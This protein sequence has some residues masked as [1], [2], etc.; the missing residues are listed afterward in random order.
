MN[1]HY[2]YIARV[3]RGVSNKFPDDA[4]GSQQSPTLAATYLRP[5]PDAD[6]MAC[7]ST[8]A[9]APGHAIHPIRGI[10]TSRVQETTSSLPRPGFAALEMV[11]HARCSLD[12][13]EP[14]QG[15]PSD[16]RAAVNVVAGESLTRSIL[17]ER[18]PE[19]LPARCHRRPTQPWQGLFGT[20]ASHARRWQR[21]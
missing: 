21:R 16:M 10:R 5:P 18:D 17:H 7:S 3:S 8:P 14:V 15:S 2:S 1:Y 11:W 12:H 19:S 9:V 6:L 13:P 20:T 4:Q